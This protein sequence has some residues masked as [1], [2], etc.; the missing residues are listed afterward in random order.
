MLRTKRR[1]IK[2]L[3]LKE[4]ISI[5]NLLQL[6]RSVECVYRSYSFLKLNMQRQRQIL[7]TGSFYVAVLQ[8]NT[9]K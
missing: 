1:L 9:R 7:R 8:T 2:R 5:R 3:V 6:R 4:W